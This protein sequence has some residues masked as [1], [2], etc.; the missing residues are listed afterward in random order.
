MDVEAEY[1]PPFNLII[2]AK[3]RIL[4]AIARYGLS[5]SSDSPDDIDTCTT[6]CFFNQESCN[7]RL[8]VETA[9]VELASKSIS[10]RLSPSAADCC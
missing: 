4:T 9:R 6:P 7:K 1:N 10:G 3:N 2:E 8:L 5:A